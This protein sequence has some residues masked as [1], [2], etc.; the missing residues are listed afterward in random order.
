MKRGEP[1]RRPAPAP[2]PAVAAYPDF[3]AARRSCN[4]GQERLVAAAA[5]PAA[6]QD[7][8]I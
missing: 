6:E 3:A 2:A 7:A 5:T 1:D 4:L 8:R